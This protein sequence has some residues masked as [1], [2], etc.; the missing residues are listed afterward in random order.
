MTDIIVDHIPVPRTARYY[1]LGAPSELTRDVWIVCHG[2]GQLAEAFIEP[3]RCVADESRVIVAPEAL[4]RFYTERTVPHTSA[5]P[6]GASWMTREDRDADIQDIVSYLDTLYEHLVSGLM[7]H[8]IARESVRVHALGFSQGA[9][10]ASRWVARGGALVDHLVAWGSAIPDDANLRA[11]GERLPAFEVDLVYGTRDAL[12]T[13][14]QLAAHEARFRG[15][16]VAYGIHAF[17]GGH[18]LHRDTIRQ[19]FIKRRG[20]QGNAEDTAKVR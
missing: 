5:S 11:I 12:M 1:T 9:A 4:S 10:A 6:I 7:R 16:G 8:G 17:D 18:T 3:F 15:A 14:E 13:I 2:Y 20:D 19:L